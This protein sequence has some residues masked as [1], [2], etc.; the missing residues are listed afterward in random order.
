MNRGIQNSSKL[1]Q[2]PF[3]APA[4]A[5]IMPVGQLWSGCPWPP[6]HRE[7]SRLGVSGR[8]R[9]GSLSRGSE[10]SWEDGEVF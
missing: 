8:G 7:M 10:P 9:Q 3:P 1:G 2:L 5:G 6:L 4:Q